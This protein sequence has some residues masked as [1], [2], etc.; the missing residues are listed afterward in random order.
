VT[1]RRLADVV[2]EGRAM[3]ALEVAMPGA[4][5]LTLLFDP[6]TALILKARYRFNG[7]PAGE[8]NV[9]EVYS[10][11]RD[12]HGLKV[13]FRIQLRREGAPAVDRTVRVFEFNIPLDSTLFSKPS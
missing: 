5:P 1:A 8:V 10:D 7:P 11:Y 9:E 6:A 12:V 4:R 13:A 2:E 3:P